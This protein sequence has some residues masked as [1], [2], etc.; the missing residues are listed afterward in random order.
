MLERR[1]TVGGVGACICRCT[2]DVAV[3]SLECRLASSD[4]IVGI[5]H[6]H[7][8]HAVTIAMLALLQEIVQ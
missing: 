2:I 8:R 4:S 1:Q 3:V 6:D 5:I 7:P